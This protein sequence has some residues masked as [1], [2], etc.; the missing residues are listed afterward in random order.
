MCS[1]HHI[2]TPISIY[3]HKHCLP[4]CLMKKN[5]SC[6][7]LRP[8]VQQTSS[9]SS[10]ER[11]CV[12][13]SL[14]RLLCHPY[15]PNGLF[16]S[17]YH[18]VPISPILKKSFDLPASLLPLYIKTP[19]NICLYPLSSILALLFSLIP[20]PARF[21]PQLLQQN[22]SCLFKVTVTSMLLNP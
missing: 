9:L 13:N 20:C 21:C 19:R 17:S 8:L 14:L 2:D 5:C 4:K 1:H 16:P 11:Y 22:D 3:T 7:S 6:F 12:S 18:E 10:T 15:S